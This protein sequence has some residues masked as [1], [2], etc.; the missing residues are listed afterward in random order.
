MEPK[1]ARR[2]KNLRPEA[3]GGTPHPPSPTS[4]TAAAESQDAADTASLMETP[5]EPGPDRP[6]GALSAPIWIGLLILAVLALGAVL[7][8]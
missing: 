5:P 3:S 8:V 4:D 6:G 2:P 7:L 1:T